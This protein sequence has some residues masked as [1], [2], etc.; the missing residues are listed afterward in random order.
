MHT[1]VSWIDAGWWCAAGERARIQKAGGHV[2]ADGRLNG[3]VQVHTHLELRTKHLNAAE[4]SW[5]TC[6]SSRCMRLQDVLAMPPGSAIPPTGVLDKSALL[7]Q[8]APAMQRPIQAA[9]TAPLL[10]PSLCRCMQVSRAFGD[11]QFKPF[12]SSAVPDVTAFSISSRDCFM[13]CGCDGF[14]GV[15]WCLGLDYV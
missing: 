6:N 14:W 3:R 15:S 7:Q 4:N 10:K 12:G 2:S 9:K 1:C 11:A 5:H 13:L 8:L